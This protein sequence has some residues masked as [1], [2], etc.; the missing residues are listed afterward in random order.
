[1]NQ[2]NPYA[3]PSAELTDIVRTDLKA[4]RRALIPRWIKIFGWIFIVMGVSIPILDGFM[5]ITG[6][7][8]S[9]ALFGLHHYGSAFHPLAIT[10]SAIILSLSVS[11]YGLLFGKSWGLNACLVTAYGSALICIGT[12]AYSAFFEGQLTIRL[13]LLVLGPYLMKL[14]RIKPL[15]LNAGS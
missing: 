8:G 6:Q 11:A 2:S 3:P 14:H 4:G 12:M 1:M 10:V 5:A 15:W 9:Y 13:E 7:P